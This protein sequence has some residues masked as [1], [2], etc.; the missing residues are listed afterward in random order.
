M[1]AMEEDLTPAEIKGRY[2]AR[3]QAEAEECGQTPP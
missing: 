1:E 3:L 2:L